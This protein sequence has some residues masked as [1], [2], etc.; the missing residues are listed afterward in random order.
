MSFI[1]IVAEPSG[2]LGASAACTLKALARA[3]AVRTGRSPEALWLE[4]RRRWSTTLRRSAARAV[5]ARMPEEAIT[6]SAPWVAAGH[7]AAYAADAW[8]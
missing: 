2:G 4:F 1:P 5:L 6:T 8:Q 3:G 7:A